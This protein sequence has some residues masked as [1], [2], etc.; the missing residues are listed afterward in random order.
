MSGPV[1][2]A[3]A[4]PP[5]KTTPHAVG[6]SPQIW[7]PDFSSSLCFLPGGYS[8]R[9]TTGFE[10]VSQCAQDSDLEPATKEGDVVDNKGALFPPKA[11]FTDRHMLANYV[12]LDLDRKRQLERDEWALLYYDRSV[13]CYT[14]RC[15]LCRCVLRR[16]LL[17]VLLTAPS[18]LATSLQSLPP[19]PLFSHGTPVAGRHGRN[20]F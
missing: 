3:S 8:L 16:W 18:L 10:I 2:K 9:R 4:V 5:D 12:W 14:S 19:R 17:V 11:V 1:G 20:S 7:S 6:T 15:V 13:G